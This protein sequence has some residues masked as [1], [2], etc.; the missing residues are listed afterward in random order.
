[1]PTDNVHILPQNTVCVWICLSPG[2]WGGEARE[3]D[4]VP[5][6]NMLKLGILSKTVKGAEHQNWGGSSSYYQYQKKEGNTSWGIMV[7]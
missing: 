2:I 6:H 3:K 5:I 7:N 4:K 1:V